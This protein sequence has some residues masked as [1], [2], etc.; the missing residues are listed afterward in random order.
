MLP[1]A[2]HYSDDDGATAA[3]LERHMARDF[4]DPRLGFV[5]LA[6]QPDRPDVDAPQWFARLQAA[7]VAQQREA[8]Q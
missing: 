6:D 3:I 4:A 2:A 5:R 8:V 7:A 1:T